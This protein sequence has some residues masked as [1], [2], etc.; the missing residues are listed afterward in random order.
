MRHLFIT[1]LRPARYR[2]ATLL[3][4]GVA[5]A[6]LAQAHPGTCN[7]TP[8]GGSPCAAPGSINLV[9]TEPGI[10]TSAGNPIDL[11]SGNKYQYETDLLSTTG[12][13]HPAL[14]RHYSANDRRRSFMGQGWHLDYDIRVQSFGQ[15]AVITQANGARLRLARTG[16]GFFSPTHGKLHAQAGDWLWV[17]PNQ[18]QLRFNAA[19]WLTQIRRPDGTALHILRHDTAGPLLHA[20]KTV[21]IT[22]APGQTQA[23]T[24]LKPRDTALHFSYRV[25]EGRAYLHAV[26]SPVGQFMYDYAQAGDE[27]HLRLTAMQRPDGSRR[28]YQYDPTRQAGNPYALTGIDNIGAPPLGAR[29]RG[30]RWAYNPSGQVIQYADQDHA[31]AVAYHKTRPGRQ[32]TQVR[33]IKALSARSP[34]ANTPAPPESTTQ[35]DFDVQGQTARLTAVTGAGCPG[36]PA[37]GTRA[38]YNRLG[39]LTQVNGT[40]LHRD[41]RQRLREIAPAHAGWA[42]LALH[43]NAQGQR[44]AWFSTLTGTETLVYDAQGLPLQRRF[45][46]GGY[47]QYTYDTQG[48]PVRLLAR[49]HTQ[50]PAVETQLQWQGRQLTQVHHPNETEYRRHD[51]Q[52]RLVARTLSRPDNG[53]EPFTERFAY[54]AQHRLIRHDVAEGGAL[55]YTWGHGRQLLA[56][57]WETR[58]GHHHAVI[59][60][61][62]GTRNNRQNKGYAFGNG[63]HL[64]TA[65]RA[66]ESWLLMSGGTPARH[67]LRAQRYAHDAQ[68]RV[69]TEH[70]FRRPNNAPPAHPL[71]FTRYVYKHDRTSRLVAATL[72]PQQAP[73]LT[74]PPR[75]HP[76]NAT[77]ARPFWYAHDDNGAALAVRT[78]AASPTQYPGINRNADGLPVQVGH[79]QLAYGP[80]RRLKTVHQADGTSITYAHNAFGQRIRRTS[81][82]GTTHY[83]F[84]DR[85]LAAETWRPGAS[86]TGDTAAPGNRQASPGARVSRRYIYAH[87][88][89]IGFIDYT[90]AAPDGTLFYVHADL[91][92]AP[93]WITNSRQ[94]IVWE[95]DYEPWG[96]AVI[97]NRPATTT[98]TL[99][100]NLRAPGQYFD[101]MTG[102]H[103]NLLRTYDPD[104]GHYLEPDPL[105]PVPGNAA[106]GYAGGQPRRHVDPLGLLLFAFDGTRNDM[107]T[108]TN[109]WRLSQ[110][111]T[112]DTV[113]YQ[114]GPGNPHNTDWDAVTAYSAPRIIDAQWQSLLN[115]LAAAPATPDAAIPIDIIGYSRGAAMA[116]HFG[117]QVSQYV[118]QGLF[119]FHDLQRGLV[120]ACVDLRFMGLF[121]T[122]AQFGLNG[123]HNAAYDL[124][125]NAGWQW[126]AHAIAL[127]ERRALFPLAGAA[128]TQPGNVVEAP[129]VGA[130]ADIGGGVL[131]DSQG[132]PNRRGDL[133]NVALNWMLWQARAA[134]VELADGTPGDTAVNA[135]Y[136]HDDRSATLRSLQD[137]DRRLD[138]AAGTLWHTYQDQHARLGH[139]S[140]AAA[141]AFIDRY[142]NWRRSAGSEVATVDMA[143][144]TRWLETVMAWP[145]PDTP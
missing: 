107:S 55:H 72:Y 22:G 53:P 48:R 94:D 26:D 139:A 86:A 127:H 51:T 135:P 79:R 140:R 111:Y 24:N 145:P 71:P 61:A 54:D 12:E 110:R 50:T 75:L 80:D 27:P 136:L 123:Q 68:G 46:G 40:T 73:L 141:E 108:H 119:S 134:G 142:D 104:F 5:G 30:G 4:C 137:G 96:R 70:V 118:N 33:R 117:N 78:S 116:R 74:R 59:G 77:P 62:T 82:A 88:V 20:V 105:G 92:G 103:D 67:I 124:T 29:H 100:F 138:R 64:L 65:L 102:W 25:H 35:I 17:W 83:W 1:G 43:Y 38:S 19:G 81:P 144:Y 91:T 122:V 23:R 39:Q 131:Y 28:Q 63:I 132:Q 13:P 98:P 97:V 60:K 15:V 52:G 14:T 32:H 31:Y 49:S 9:G 89:P 21:D 93:R 113:F 143:A 47:W 101:D 115:T 58:A 128:D 109:V 7:S 42:G 84:L 106:L 10:N 90:P 18:Q 114:P 95:A 34:P 45:A 44:H 8:A 6:C 36:C 125:V 76:A 2:L 16:N 99:T 56:V 87:H 121:D 129:F 57:S 69:V 66:D 85:R 126:V 130:H 3:L 133:H 120:T 37:P 11:A 41:T 112:E